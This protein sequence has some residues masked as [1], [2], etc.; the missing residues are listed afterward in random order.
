M[1]NAQDQN[2]IYDFNLFG[3]CLRSQQSF[4]A[5]F[6]WRHEAR[7]CWLPHGKVLYD[8]YRARANSKRYSST[9]VLP[10]NVSGTQAE[11]RMDCVTFGTGSDACG[12]WGQPHLQESLLESWLETESQCILAPPVSLRLT[13]CQTR[14]P[15]KPP[16]VINDEDNQ[17]V[18]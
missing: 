1:A 4:L 12:Y 7:Y 16:K 8:A 11:Q 3:K 14:N 18:L 17:I 13:T 15:Q 2:V 10:L 9:S 6:R 5:F